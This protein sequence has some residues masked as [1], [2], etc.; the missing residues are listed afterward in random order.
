MDNRKSSL[1]CSS[2]LERYYD[3]KDYS[4]DL[5]KICREGDIMELYKLPFHI[6]D[7]NEKDQ[8][9][10]TPLSVAL[11]THN[12]NCALELLNHGALC[13]SEDV[14][15]LEDAYFKALESGS[16]HDIV[17]YLRGGIDPNLITKTGRSSMSVGFD[18]SVHH[19]SPEILSV[20]IGHGGDVNSLT[21]DKRPLILAAMDR[22]E[23][24]IVDLLVKHRANL[25]MTA[26]HRRRTIFHVM[27]LTRGAAIHV[28][29]SILDRI[30]RI[31]QPLVDWP[32]AFF[33]DM[34]YLEAEDSSGDT[35]LMN[36][37]K[38][39]QVDKIDIL[40][41]YGA[42]PNNT[43]RWNTT[44]LL[45]S[46]FKRAGQ[47]HMSYN[48]QCK[49]NIIRILLL[50]NANEDLVGCVK[51]GENGPIEVLRPVELA[52]RTG[53]LLAAK[54]LH[55]VA[56]SSVYDLPVSAIR[57]M[58]NCGHV[59]DNQKQEMTSWLRQAQQ[60]PHKLATICRQ[61]VRHHMSRP[62][63]SSLNTFHLPQSMVRFLT[64][65]DD[66]DI[67]AQELNFIF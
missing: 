57:W 22:Q 31:S 33:Q 9:H 44:P 49:M 48:K 8:N 60:T 15:L 21:S 17:A 26:E 47:I 11:Q 20:L 16:T 64:L 41:R 19:K 66:I 7:I 35:A 50:H 12:M 58:D 36:A 52:I 63:I 42:D 59:L 5:H 43:D 38:S 67:L 30:V 3:A 32:N 39:G 27:C 46:L 37:C 24:P 54:I 65:E 1:E 25:Q 6:P 23:W 14:V 51:L 55:H 40:L 61:M 18:A 10:Q 13:D 62:F 2:V 34:P 53:Q 45:L 28:L 29:K 4:Y 56:G